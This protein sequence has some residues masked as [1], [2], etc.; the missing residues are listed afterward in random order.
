MISETNILYV[1]DAAVLTFLQGLSFSS[2]VFGV[3]SADTVIVRYWALNKDFDSVDGPDRLHSKFTDNLPVVTLFGS[4]P[5]PDVGRR[6]I[7]VIRDWYSEES[8][9]VTRDKKFRLPKPYTLT[10]QIDLWSRYKAHMN[11]MLQELLYAFD[12]TNIKYLNVALPEPMRNKYLKLEIVGGVAD[13]SDLEQEEAHKDPQFRK[14]LTVEADIWLY[15]D[16]FPTLTERVDT[17]STTF[18]DL[19]EVELDPEYQVT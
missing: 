15:K 19:D 4:D 9:G 3:G 5:E 18:A 1:Y 8:G 7:G 2:A 11:Q 16:E 12:D 6:R 17:V 10:Y 14:T 13:N